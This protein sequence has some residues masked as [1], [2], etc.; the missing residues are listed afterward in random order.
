MEKKLFPNAKLL[1][2]FS[3]TSAENKGDVKHLCFFSENGWK[4]AV[5]CDR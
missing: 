4:H 1:I 2:Y 5:V 3:N